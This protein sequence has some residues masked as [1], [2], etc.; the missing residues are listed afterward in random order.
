MLFFFEIL[1]FC[2][3]VFVFFF[4]FRGTHSEAE[5]NSAVEIGEIHRML[6]RGSPGLG[7]SIN[8]HKMQGRTLVVTIASL[9]EHAKL[10]PHFSMPLDPKTMKNK[11]FKPPIY[12]L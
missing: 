5:E 6:P 11:G 7:I 10:I 4:F 2:S 9:G 8:L 3:Q 1:P 12:G